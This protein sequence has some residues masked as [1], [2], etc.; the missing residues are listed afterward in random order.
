MEI[1]DLQ[2]PVKVTKAGAL[3]EWFLAQSDPTTIT[4]EQIGTKCLELE[5][6]GGSVTYYKNAY[7]L[8][9][10]LANQMK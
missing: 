5:M 10:E 8:A 2:P 4:S 1:K 3:K 9:I 6:K 7:K